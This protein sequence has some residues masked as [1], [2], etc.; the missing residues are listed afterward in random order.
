[1]NAT[2]LLAAAQHILTYPVAGGLSP[3]LAAIL[4]RQALEQI[5]DE[6]CAALNAST[7]WATMRSKLIVLRALDAAEAADGAALAWN[8]LSTACHVHAYEMQPSAAEVQ[9]VC[10]MI[11][12]VVPQVER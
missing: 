4:A 1:M 2:E 6:R 12:S 11:A 7:P 3:R 10:D 5:V 9:T 8:R